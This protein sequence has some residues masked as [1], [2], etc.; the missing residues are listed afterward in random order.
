MEIAETLMTP[1]DAS[2]LLEANTNNRLL[3]PRRV[4]AL[5]A[6]IARGEWIVDGNPVKVSADGVLLDGQHRLAAIVQAKQTVPVLVVTGLPKDSQLVMDSGRSRSFAD[7]LRIRGVSNV[8]NVAAAIRLLWMYNEGYL[9]SSHGWHT[10][11]AANQQLW[12]LFQARGEDVA[13]AISATRPVR[14]HLMVPPSACAVAWLIFVQLDGDDCV[15]FFAQL[16]MQ[17]PMEAS[18]VLALARLLSNR[19]RSDTGSVNQQILMALT[20]KA[21]NAYRNGDEVKQLMWRRGGS[22]R[23]KFPVP[24]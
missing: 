20:I 5:S 19:E 10:A 4:N 16:G 8:S 11:V 13:A 3:S 21:W 6:C 18:A 7:Y 15:D 1:A 14:Q 22:G 17:R 23:E 2:K 12:A 9:A 24:I